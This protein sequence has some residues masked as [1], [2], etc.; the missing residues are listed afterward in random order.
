MLWC[1]AFFPV[2]GLL[3]LRSRDAT[4]RFHARQSC[5]LGMWYV[6]VLTGF[7]LADAGIGMLSRSAG[8]LMHD[9]S[10]L[11]GAAMFVLWVYCFWRVAAQR[12]CVLPIIGRWAARN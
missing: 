3:W 9:A 2:S 10:V 1:Y 4:L 7:S 8:Q 6:V 5:A 11:L 12:A